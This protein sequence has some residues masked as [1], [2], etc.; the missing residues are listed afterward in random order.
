MGINT[1]TRSDEDYTAAL[2]DLLPVYLSDYRLFKGILETM[3]AQ[4]RATLLVGDNRP[5]DLR[6]N[7]SGLS[8]PALVMAGAYDLILGPRHATILVDS[9]PHARLALFTRSGHFAHIE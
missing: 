4:L 3:H 9:L 6:D 8:V 7:L 5:F 2:R 1:A